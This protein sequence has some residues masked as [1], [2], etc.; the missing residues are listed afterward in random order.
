MHAMVTHPK[1][2]VSTLDANAVVEDIQ[3][4]AAGKA[5]VEG[6]L[7]YRRLAYSG[8]NMNVIEMPPA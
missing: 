2:P 4:K 1:G 5:A 6:E 8:S 3:L 7:L